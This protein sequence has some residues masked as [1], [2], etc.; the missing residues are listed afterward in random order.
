MRPSRSWRRAPFLSQARVGRAA[1][2]PRCNNLPNGENPS[3]QF[4]GSHPRGGPFESGL[5]G[6]ARSA[7]VA[8]SSACSYHSDPSRL[9]AF[10]GIARIAESAAALGARILEANFVSVL[11]TQSG[12]H[13]D[14]SHLLGPL[15]ADGE[16]GGPRLRKPD[17]RRFHGS[18]RR[19][20]PAAGNARCVRDLISRKIAT[21]QAGPENW[22]LALRAVSLPR[23]PRPG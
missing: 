2:A 16:K 21:T 20:P 7:C 11:T 15:P 13:K 17:G 14:P 5:V 6:W 19:C 3:C 10:T 22:P 8:R 4:R 9:P 18:G 1:P 12:L 23:G